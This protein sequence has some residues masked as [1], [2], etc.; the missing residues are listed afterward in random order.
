MEAL[1]ITLYHA[2]C[3]S[4][5][6]VVYAVVV[7]VLAHSIHFTIQSHPYCHPNMSLLLLSSFLINFSI[8][9]IN[10]NCFIDT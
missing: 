4:T 2:H 7:S 9:I 6:V 10:T 3:I 8:V 1:F 5:Y